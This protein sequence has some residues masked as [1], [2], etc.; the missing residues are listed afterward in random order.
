MFSTFLIT[1][2]LIINIYVDILSQNYILNKFQDDDLENL[3]KAE[4]VLVL[5]ASV[6]SD[7]TLSDVL[8]DRALNALEIYEKGKA[9]KILISGAVDGN[10]NEPLAM[11]KYFLKKGVAEGDLLID[12]EGS[13][14][15]ESMKNAKEIFE[16]SS[17]IIPTQKF[18]VNRAVYIARS[19]DMNAYGVALEDDNYLDIE[20]FRLREMF[21]KAAA[22]LLRSKFIE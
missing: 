3:L 12:F 18:H 6:Y 9:E 2:L 10:Y 7:G 11:K 16:I 1:P 5:G 22:F 17:L 13:S 14:T 8:E 20:K 4:V 19:L 21:G 15:F